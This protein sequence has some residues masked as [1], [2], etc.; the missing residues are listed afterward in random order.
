MLVIGFVLIVHGE[1]RSIGPL[2]VAA[3]GA[4][5]GE[6]LIKEG[7]NRWHGRSPAAMFFWPSVI[8]FWGVILFVIGIWQTIAFARLPVQD[9]II[10]VCGTIFRSGIMLCGAGLLWVGVQRWRGEK[11]KLALD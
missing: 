7:L 1:P 3:V 8:I 11:L 6:F 2:V 4:L 9:E 5:I 10:K